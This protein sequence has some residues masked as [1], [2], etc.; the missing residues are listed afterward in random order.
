MRIAM[1]GI[2]I[3][4][5]RDDSEVVACR[6]FD[7]LREDFAQS[8]IFMD[9]ASI[10]IG[11]DFREHLKDAVG[12]C[13]VVLVVIGQDWLKADDGGRRRIDDPNDFVRIEVKGALDRGIPVIPILPR[14][15]AMPRA[16]DLPDDLRELAYRNAAEVDPGKDFN[17]YMDRVVKHLKELIAP[18]R[19]D[20]AT[21][22]R[23][24]QALA[25][26]YDLL[27]DAMP[28]GGARTL[29]LE[30]IVRVMRTLGLACLP[31]LSEFADSRLP[32]EWLS[33]V[34]ML[35]VQP[36]PAYFKWLARRLKEKEAFIQYH[37][38]VALLAAARQADQS[39]RQLLESLEP[40]IREAEE[41]V[42]E[43]SDRKKV[44][45]QLLEEIRSWKN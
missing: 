16:E 21:V 9:V 42:P 8:S 20:P 45:R 13:D 6:I 11:V 33:A 35:Q 5:R 15:T 19:D 2:F 39:Q 24:M 25:C 40:D 44:L 32:G 26:T 27:R 1:P 29:T 31:Y 7:R 41:A 30:A 18:S 38:A 43:G 22:Q 36:N 17:L 28:Q 10:P 14:P 37:A 12:Q 23:Q 3:C 34:A 4:Y